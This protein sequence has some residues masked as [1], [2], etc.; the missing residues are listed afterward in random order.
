[1]TG[2][3]TAAGRKNPVRD[4]LVVWFAGAMAATGLGVGAALLRPEQ[5][6]LV[7][8]VFAASSLAPCIALAWILLDAGRWVTPDPHAEE[9]VESRWME[10]AGS[11]ALFDVVAVTGVT[12][13][14]VSLLELDLPA[15]LA[16]MG[17]IAFALA[18]GGLR[19]ALLTRRES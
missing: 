1:M 8:G 9:N 7:L 2:T 12:A 10:K 18:D 17:V 6:W 14:V 16:L 4:L 15:D 5:F 13:A 11:R 19:Y 3:P